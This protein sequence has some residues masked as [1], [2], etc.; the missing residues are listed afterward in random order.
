MC[1]GRYRPRSRADAGIGAG[2]KLLI[3]ILILMERYK[4]YH[5]LHLTMPKEIT[6]PLRINADLWKK[7]KETFPRTQTPTE[8]LI[9]IIEGRVERFGEEQKKGGEE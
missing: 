5:L 9:G 7:F 4:Y 2:A 6:Y 3:L 1:L 8:V